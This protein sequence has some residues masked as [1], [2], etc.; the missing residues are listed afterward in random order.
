M[1]FYKLFKVISK[2]F[3]VENKVLKQ[4][5]N[6]FKS[7]NLFTTVM[8]IVKVLTITILT[9]MYFKFVRIRKYNEYFWKSKSSRGLEKGNTPILKSTLQKIV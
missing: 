6:E 8:A 3:N 2:K 4:H 7:V 1:T 9:Q 5:S